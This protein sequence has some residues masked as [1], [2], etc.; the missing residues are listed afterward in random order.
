MKSRV[1]TFVQFMII[2]VFSLGPDKT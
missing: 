1:W 2:I